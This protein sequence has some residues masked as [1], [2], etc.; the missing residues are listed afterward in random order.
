M[1][2]DKH[3]RIVHKTGT[4]EL[5]TE[6]MAALQVSYLRSIYNCLKNYSVLGSSCLHVSLDFLGFIEPIS[7]FK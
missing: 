7:F 1:A 5:V 2:F 3:I 4:D 6:L